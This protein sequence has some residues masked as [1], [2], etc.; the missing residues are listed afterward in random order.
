MASV[1]KFIADP[2]QPQE[3]PEDD[4]MALREEIDQ[5]SMFE[6]IVGTSA[7]LRRVLSLVCKVAPTDASVLVTGETGTG[8]ELI[9]RAI[10]KRSHRPSRAFVS[11]NCAAI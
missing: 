8:K 6:E 3:K 2:K 5:A 4:N 11:V 10:H 7:A 9:A 1:A